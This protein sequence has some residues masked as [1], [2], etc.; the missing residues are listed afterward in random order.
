M[1]N[2]MIEVNYK[3]QIIPLEHAFWYFMFPAVNIF[4]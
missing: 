4:E 2:Q 3:A 1:L